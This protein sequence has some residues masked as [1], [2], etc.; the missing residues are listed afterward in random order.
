MN[1]LMLS[2]MGGAVRLGNLDN[3]NKMPFSGVLTYLNVPSDLPP[4]GSGGLKVLIPLDVGKEAVESLKGMPVNLKSSMDDHDSQK[5]V[6]IFEDAWVGEDSGDGIPI[7]VKGHIFA[8]NFPDEAMDIKASQN[9]LGFSYETGKTSLESSEYN[10]EQV[11]KAK[12]LIF[13]GAAILFKKSAAYQKTSLAA[14]GVGNMSLPEGMEALTTTLLEA[15]GGL[16]DYVDTR[17]DQFQDVLEKVNIANASE[18]VEEEFEDEDEIKASGLTTDQ[19]KKMDAKDFA[20]PSKRAFPMNDEKHVRMAWDM[21]NRKKGLTDAEK[22]E[23]RNNIL[24]RAKELG[25]DTSDWNK[26]LKG[27]GDVEAKEIS[28]A[29]EKLTTVVTTLATDV[30]ELKAGKAQEGTSTEGTGATEGVGATVNAGAGAEPPRKSKE[31]IAKFEKGEGQTEGDG[32][33]ETDVFASIDKQNLDPIMS[34][35]EKLAA[36]YS[37]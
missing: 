13:T 11:A 14:K 9:D 32:G 30:A 20:L 22:E 19:R 21:V 33:K 28:A 3:P 16:K 36:V 12:K 4:G 23:A 10:G 5:V 15:I 17:L 24:K 6:G 26:N 34:M 2:A 37:K 27:D 1:E 7:H 31:L 18:E 35:A 29:L 25:V 8:K